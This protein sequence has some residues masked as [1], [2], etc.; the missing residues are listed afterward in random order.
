[1]FTLLDAMI[2]CAPLAPV[3]PGRSDWYRL[4]QTQDLASLADP[5]RPRGEVS[6]GEVSRGEVS[7]LG[8]PQADPALGEFWYWDARLRVWRRF[9]EAFEA[10]TAEE[11][12]C[13]AEFVPL[14][15]RR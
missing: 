15:I 11:I 6:R 4:V 3:D 2:L 12:G 9:P 7:Q 14:A 8:L 1:M 10:H 13:D 5:A